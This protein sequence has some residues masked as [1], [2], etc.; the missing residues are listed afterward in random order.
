MSAAVIE[1]QTGARQI[2]RRK[3]GAPGRVLVW[4][5]LDLLVQY[6]ARQD[7]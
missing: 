5:L 1:T 6:E 3:A 2:Y 4:E 7:G